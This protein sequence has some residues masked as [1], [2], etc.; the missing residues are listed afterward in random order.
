MITG[1][2]ETNQ[3]MLP[4]NYSI[5]DELSRLNC[6]G[7]IPVTRPS[8]EAFGVYATCDMFAK[9]RTSNYL[10]NFDLKNKDGIQ[11]QLKLMNY[12]S[13][14]IST[15]SFPITRGI[16]S[17]IKGS[18]AQICYITYATNQADNPLTRTSSGEV[19]LYS[20][21]LAVQIMDG[22]L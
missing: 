10:F 4:G 3:W 11:V 8:R 1:P 6:L 9:W 14:K 5:N 21:Q 18:M 12:I 7:W 2:N 22:N 15:S 17:S 16:P 20:Q 19:T 13:D